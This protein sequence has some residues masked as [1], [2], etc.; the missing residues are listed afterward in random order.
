MSSRVTIQVLEGLER[1][2]VYGALP[3]PVSIGREED[4]TVRLNDDRVSRF[5]A[6][7]QANGER[8]ILTDLGSTNGTRVNGRPVQVRLLRAGDQI[9]IG[10]CLL[11]FGSPEEIAA[12]GAESGVDL[13]GQAEAWNSDSGTG[14]GDSAL[15]ADRFEDSED[16]ESDPGEQY[17]PAW[18]TLPAG[19]TTLQAVEISEL[20]GHV[21]EQLAR[22]IA[23][24]R[25]VR[26]HE[27]D[28]EMHL[29]RGGWQRLLRLEM[30]LAVGLRK[31]LEPDDE[32]DE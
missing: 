3:L 8:I 25:E 12:A 23:S 31:A 14:Y 29:S 7:L 32:D 28:S 10:R 5:H 30:D 18:A 26:P 19:L 16:G 9:T 1:G 21:H 27:D 13:Q 17:D 2:R 20:L 4:N 11:L 15:V 24:A 22:L 6:K